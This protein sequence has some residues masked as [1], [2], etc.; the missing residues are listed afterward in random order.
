MLKIIKSMSELQE[1]QL[2]SV[3]SG[4]ITNAKEVCYLVDYLREDFFRH[5][6]ACCC[7]WSEESVYKS[8]LRLEPYRDGLL[9]QALETVPD[10]RKKG[11]GF[12]LVKAVLEY[13][14]RTEYKCVY[15][16]VDKRNDASLNL[17]RKCGFQKVAD[18]AILLDGTV[19]ANYYTLCYNL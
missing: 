5:K 13:C 11:Y 9:L 3:Y 7:V 17:H 15:S 18:S 16:H 14:N 2:L 12:L 19:T 1:E 8:A 6:D 4:S 10:A